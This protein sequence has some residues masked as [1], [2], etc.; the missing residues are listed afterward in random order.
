M[1][2][3]RTLEQLGLASSGEARWYK[4]LCCG[5]PRSRARSTTISDASAWEHER[6]LGQES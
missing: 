6:Q 5:Q 2:G 3:S 1:V 4:R